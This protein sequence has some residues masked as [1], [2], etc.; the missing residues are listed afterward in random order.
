M[1]FCHGIHLFFISSCSITFIFS[2]GRRGG[3][4]GNGSGSKYRSPPPPFSA[5]VLGGCRR[6]WDSK[7]APL[8]ALFTLQVVARNYESCTREGRRGTRDNKESVNVSLCMQCIVTKVY[9]TEY[10]EDFNMY[11]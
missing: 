11:I 1:S 6:M 10:V 8:L 9:R 5:V 4:A 7:K 3:G 2:H